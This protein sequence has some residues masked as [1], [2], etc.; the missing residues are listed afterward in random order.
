M[1]K[2]VY[3]VKKVYLLLYIVAKNKT[4]VQEKHTTLF[5]I[6]FYI[7]GGQITFQKKKQ[8]QLKTVIMIL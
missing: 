3:R 8:K 4:Y 7:T 2:W 6:T 5:I 1:T